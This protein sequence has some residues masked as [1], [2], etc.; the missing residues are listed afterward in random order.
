MIVAEIKKNLNNDCPSPPTIVVPGFG[1]LSL[2]RVA[3]RVSIFMNHNVRNLMRNKKNLSIVLY[4]F[5]VL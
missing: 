1:L 3:R 4:V 2:I 5:S